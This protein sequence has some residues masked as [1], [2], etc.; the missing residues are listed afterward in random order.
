MNRHKS[1]KQFKKTCAKSHN[2]QIH[3]MP[4]MLAQYFTKSLNTW[5]GH[6]N[7]LQLSLFMALIT[8]VLIITSMLMLNRVKTAEL[9][10]KL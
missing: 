4:K 9:L 1:T 5:S 2:S 6:D 3:H 10:L 7:F 8:S